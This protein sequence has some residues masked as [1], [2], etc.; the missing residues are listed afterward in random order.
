MRGDTLVT[1]RRRGADALDYLTL[2]IK[3]YAWMEA[4]RGRRRTPE[5]DAAMAHVL[6]VIRA[7][8]LRARGRGRSARPGRRAAAR[9]SATARDDGGSDDPEPGRARPELTGGAR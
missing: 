2:P 8:L 7:F 1:G 9:R 3:D 4:L 6:A 5:V